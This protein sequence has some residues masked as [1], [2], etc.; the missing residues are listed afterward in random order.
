MSGR[1]VSRPRG[2]IDSFDSRLPRECLNHSCWTDLLKARDVIG[3]FKYEHNH[4]HSSVA[5]RALVEY[6]A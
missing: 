4:V 5:D 6:G 2:Y 3:D 1:A